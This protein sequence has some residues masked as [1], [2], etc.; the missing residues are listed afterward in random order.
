DAKGAAKAATATPKAAPA[1]IC[2]V[3]MTSPN[4]LEYQCGVREAIQS[5]AARE[6]VSVYTMSPAAAM[7]RAAGLPP[8]AGSTVARSA[9]RKAIARTIQIASHAI[10]RAIQNGRLR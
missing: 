4:A 1:S 2:P 6:T 7:R 3:A 9:R 5:T 10:A 8:L